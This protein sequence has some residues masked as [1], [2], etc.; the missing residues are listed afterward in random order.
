MSR[1]E[2]TVLRDDLGGEGEALEVTFEHDG[3]TYTLDLNDAHADELESVLSAH[4]K[5]IE[6]ANAAL[7]SGLARF[8]EAAGTPSRV[9][10]TRTASRRVAQEVRNWAQANSVAVSARGPV[11]AEVLA[12]YRA[13]HGGAIPTPNYLLE[14]RATTRGLDAGIVRTWARENNV[15]VNARGPLS[16]TAL[17]A[18]LAAHP[19]LSVVSTDDTTDLASV[20]AW[21]KENGVKVSARGPVAADVLDAYAAAHES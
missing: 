8:V 17:D 4:V 6:E 13:A 15:P 7:D 3:R 12:A 16:R 1:H 18:Y 14:R 10:L 19:D 11:G 21:A 9:R 20:R 5:A 2:V